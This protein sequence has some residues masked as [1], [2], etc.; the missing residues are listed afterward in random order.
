MIREYGRVYPAKVPLIVY[1]T[2]R[3]EALG[4]AALDELKKNYQHLEMDQV[5]NLYFI[6]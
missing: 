2:A 3:Q 6:H 5:L 4:L 1:L